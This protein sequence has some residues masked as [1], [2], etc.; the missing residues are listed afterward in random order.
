MRRILFLHFYTKT[1]LDPVT[2]SGEGEFDLNIFK[3]VDVTNSFMGL[4]IEDRKCQN[5]ENFVDCTTRQHLDNVLANCGCLPMS[6]GSIMKNVNNLNTRRM[7]PR[8][9]L[10]VSG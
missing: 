1:F 3:Q 8:K 10:K 7:Q 4:P 6:I 2:L 9:S 5:E